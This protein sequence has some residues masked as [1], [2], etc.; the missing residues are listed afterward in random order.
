MSHSIGEV[1]SAG[2]SM[3]DQ[4]DS[5]SR[6]SKYTADQVQSSVDSVHQIAEMVADLRGLVRSERSTE[7]AT[8]R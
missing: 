8:S 1:A 7:H 3:S 2:R 4:V 5:V 6:N